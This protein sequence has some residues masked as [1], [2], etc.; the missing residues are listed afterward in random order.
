MKPTLPLLFALALLPALHAAT[1]PDGQFDRTFSIAGTVDLDAMTRAGG[2]VVTRGAA[3]GTVR[4]HGILEARENELFGI[5]FSSR[6]ADAHIR[7]LERNP[8]VERSGNKV[9]VGYMTD[10]HLLDGVSMHLE[11]EVPADTSVKARAVSG[12]IEISG[13]R[14]P[15]DSSAVSGGIRLRDIGADVSA[16][17]TSGGVRI[18]DVNGAVSAHTV[19]GGIEALDV[20]GA[21]DA[22]AISGGVRLSQTR[23]A[24]IRAETISGGVRATLASGS[25]YNV[26][27]QTVNG[28]ITTPEMTVESGFSRRHIAG[29]IRGGGPEVSIRST[30]GPVRVD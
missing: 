29:K 7:E 10:S 9:R 19:S 24:S 26:D 18:S 14:G 22:R 23:V 1:R 4:I 16:R 11:I 5:F 12:G 30:S 25:G 2:I 28:H 17:T 20:T 3:A 15:V 6:D 21:I 13:V 27:I 8:P